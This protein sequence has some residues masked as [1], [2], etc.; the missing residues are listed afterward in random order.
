MVCLSAITIA[1]AF[2]GHFDIPMGLIS[3]VCFLPMVIYFSEQSTKDRIS[4]LE[5]RIIEL[6]EAN[7][8]SRTNGP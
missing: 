4:R 5:A 8:A 6:E 1:P 3:F 2:F 7:K